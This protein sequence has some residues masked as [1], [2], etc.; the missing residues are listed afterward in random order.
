MSTC[1]CSK[2]EKYVG[3]CCEVNIVFSFV[4]TRNHINSI[5]KGQDNSVFA[6]NGAD[7]VFK[8]WFWPLFHYQTVDN[9][10]NRR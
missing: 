8:F 2:A 3:S 7:A 1:H 10:D 4:D 5:V 9:V 6:E